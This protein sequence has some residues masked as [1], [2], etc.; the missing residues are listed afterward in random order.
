MLFE[1]EAPFLDNVEQRLSEWTRVDTEPLLKDDASLDRLDV[2]VDRLVS[3]DLQPANE[4][5][6]VNCLSNYSHTFRF[7]LT[8]T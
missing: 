8:L 1:H 6:S 3:V 4:Q 2:L 5:K 7:I